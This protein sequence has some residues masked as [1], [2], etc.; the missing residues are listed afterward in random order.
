MNSSDKGN[1][2]WKKKKKKSLIPGKL[3]HLRLQAVH[4]Y[5]NLAE[6][7]ETSNRNYLEAVHHS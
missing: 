6:Q 2:G 5:K 1:S 3:Q 4:R 7:R